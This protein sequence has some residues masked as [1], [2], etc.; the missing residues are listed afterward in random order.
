MFINYCYKISFKYVFKGHDRAIIEIRGNNTQEQGQGRVDDEIH[1]YL[2]ARY[3]W[4]AV[5]RKG[6]NSNFDQNF[7]N[8]TTQLITVMCTKLA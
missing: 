4:E 7:F 8:W 6:G 1:L 5:S 3:I 2:D